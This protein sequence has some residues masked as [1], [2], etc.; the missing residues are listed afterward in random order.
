MAGPLT[1]IRVLD[2]TTVV[3][4]PYATQILADFGADVIKVEPPGGDVMRYAWP[5][6]HPG[7]GHIFLNANRNKRSIV[8]DLKQA[9]ALEVCLALAKKSDV[10]VYNIRPQAMTRLRLSYEDLRKQIQR[11]SMSGASATAS[12]D[13]T[14]R[15]PPMTI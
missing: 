1:G 2:L 12:A 7:M 11:S 9:A 3:M 10:L 14:P 13:P 8:L 5:F 15:R 4:G 6:R